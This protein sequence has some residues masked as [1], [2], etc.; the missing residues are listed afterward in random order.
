MTYYIRNGIICKIFNSINALTLYFDQGVHAMT[1]P[2]ITL[3]KKHKSHGGFIFILF[4]GSM[5]SVTL[6]RNVAIQFDV[7]NRNWPKLHRK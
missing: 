5:T 4:Y 6:N 3:I 2:L 1:N 7:L